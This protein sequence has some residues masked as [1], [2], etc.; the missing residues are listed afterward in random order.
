M[1]FEVE[2]SETVFIVDCQ[3]MNVLILLSLENRH[4]VT[5]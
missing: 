2:V 4:V 5:C 1:R 3:D